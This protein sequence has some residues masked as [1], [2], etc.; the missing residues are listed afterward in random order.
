MLSMYDSKQEEGSHFLVMYST[1]NFY[2]NPTK[3]TV[4]ED[5]RSQKIPFYRKINRSLY[6]NYNNSPFVLKKKSPYDE[7]F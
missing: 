4:K 5:F 3:M 7:Y 6:F 2:N 1:F